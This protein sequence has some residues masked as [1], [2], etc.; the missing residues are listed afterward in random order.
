MKFGLFDAI[1]VVRLINQLDS[2]DLATPRNVGGA[3]AVDKFTNSI[4]EIG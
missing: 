1:S 4:L 3:Q 2:G